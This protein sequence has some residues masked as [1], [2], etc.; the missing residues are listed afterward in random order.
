MS[1]RKAKFDD[2]WRTIFIRN[3][4]TQLLSIGIQGLLCLADTQVKIPKG[5][6][7]IV[8]GNGVGKSALLAAITELLGNS[9]CSH[10]V[11]HRVRL[12]NSSLTASANDK[13]ARKELAAIRLD[14]GTRTSGESRFESALHWIEPSFIVS[15]TQNKLNSDLGFREMLE[16]LSP[17]DLDEDDCSALSYILGKKVDACSIFEISDYGEID[18]FPYFYMISGGIKYGSEVMGFGEL[19]LLSIYWKLRTIGR[20][21]ILILEEP[22]AH[23]SPRSQRA[24]MDIIAKVCCDKSLTVILTTHSPAVISNLPPDNLLLLTKDGGSTKISVGASKTQVNDLLGLASLKSG[25]V[26]VEDRAASQF[27][28]SILRMK[29]IELLSQIEIVVMDSESRI[30]SA[31]K[32][33]PQVAGGWLN[34]LGMYDGDMRGKVK[35]KGVEWGFMCLPG[36]DSPEII[37]RETLYGAQ[38]GVGVLAGYLRVSESTLRASLDAVAGIDAHDWFTQLPQ[39]LRIEHSVLMD[40]LVRL[41]L[42]SPQNAVDDFISELVGRMNKV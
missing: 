37:L 4:S 30:T 7:A 28:R 42:D 36:K 19:S 1:L 16:P 18:P 9:E 17:L 3:Y 10:G 40:S 14:D 33:L 31:L 35:T 34:I 24:L 13:G 39:M 2:R 38:G 8:G 26:L 12:F 23:V 29:K 5:I 25:L 21:E 27:L 11:G 41:W 32:S 6:C 22:E 15:L 20:D